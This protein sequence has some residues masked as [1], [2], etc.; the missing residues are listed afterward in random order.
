MAESRKIDLNAVNG[1][2]VKSGVASVITEEVKQ[3]KEKYALSFEGYVKVN[4]DG[5]CHFYTLSDDGS[6]LFID[7]IEVVNNDGEHGSV[8]K[9]GKA[10]LKKGYHKIKV[11]YFDGGGGNELKVYWQAEG[12]KK[13]VLPAAVLFH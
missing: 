1:I 6:K 3:R 5:R 12:K 10:V 9:E 11:V 8:E 2:A 4:K 7:G 13:E